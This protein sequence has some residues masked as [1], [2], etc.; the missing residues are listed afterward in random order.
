MCIGN[1]YKVFRCSPENVQK[2]E[3]SLKHVEQSFRLQLDIWKY[4]RKI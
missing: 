1:T 2:Y 3:Y 4:P